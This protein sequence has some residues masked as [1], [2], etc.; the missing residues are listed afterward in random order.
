MKNKDNIFNKYEEAVAICLV[1]NP[2]V[3]YL[4]IDG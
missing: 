1:R 4:D 2:K 3:Y